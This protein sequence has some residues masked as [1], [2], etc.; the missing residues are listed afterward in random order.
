[1]CGEQGAKCCLGGV[2]T[3]TV[4]A[5]ADN[6]VKE[7]KGEVISTEEMKRLLESSINLF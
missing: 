4:K 6:V 1:M 2:V 7:G 3:K 5:I